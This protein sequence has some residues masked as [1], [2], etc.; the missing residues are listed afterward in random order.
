VPNR[1]VSL[2]PS[3]TEALFAMGAGP[4][5]VGVTEYCVHPRE[6]VAPLVKV[7]GSKLPDL[8]R[9]YELKPDLVVMNEE[10]N[11]VED[12]EEIQARGIPVLNTFPRKVLDTASMLRDVGRAVG[13]GPAAEALAR[14]VEAA[15]AAAAE[16]N[17][18]QPRVRAACLV[19]MRPF[20][21]VN[22]D[23]FL[24]DMMSL[25]GF[26]NVYAGRP[27]RYPRLDKG[28]LESA[29]RELGLEAIL[30]PNEPFEFVPQHATEIA[31][32]AGL[33]TARA[34]LCDGQALTW[35]GS[36]TPWGVE[37]AVKLARRIRSLPPLA[38]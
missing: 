26:D 29:R 1:I 16:A 27:G 32:L 31:A 18:G 5:V 25:G 30:L 13:C 23:T 37:Q 28:E 15:V 38:P 12:F 9:L 2:C 20:M 19:W 7:G 4:R 6:A 17:A 36:R 35:Y 34:V 11:R 24:H 14:D 3:I 10:E 21:T 22:G 8:E 33:P